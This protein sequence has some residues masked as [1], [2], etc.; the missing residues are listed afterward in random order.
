MP[1]YSAQI[2]P[3][4]RWRIIAYIR[5]LQMSQFADAAQLP[6]DVKNRLGAGGKP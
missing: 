1:S 2:P 6:D 5:V 3:A 4:D